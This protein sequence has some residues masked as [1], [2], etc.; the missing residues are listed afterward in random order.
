MI[1]PKMWP[2]ARPSMYGL[3][4]QFVR[5]RTKPKVTPNASIKSHTPEKQLEYW[6]KIDKETH[7]N[8]AEPKKG[9]SGERSK[10]H[11]PI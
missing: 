10:S 8:D 4:P 5:N 7:Y 3:V 2:L 1:E 6:Q 9:T 11:F